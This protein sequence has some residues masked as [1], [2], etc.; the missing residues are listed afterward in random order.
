MLE[1]RDEKLKLILEE[2]TQ[3]VRAFVA[4]QISVLATFLLPRE[5]KA[6]EALRM[7]K[8]VYQLNALI[9]AAHNVDS[10]KLTSRTKYIE[11]VIFPP[12]FPF[13][14]FYFL[15]QRFNI[16]SAARKYE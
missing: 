2:A 7:P 14:W 6:S 8:F 5:P 12:S 15:S 11:K 9:S 13:V 16:L 3:N 10:E 1:C 4:A